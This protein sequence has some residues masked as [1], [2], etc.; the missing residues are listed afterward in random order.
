MYTDLDTAKQA[1]LAEVKQLE[2]EFLLFDESWTN[3]QRASLAQR[4]EN[5]MQFLQTIIEVQAQVQ[6]NDAVANLLLSHL[7]LM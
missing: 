7:G 4:Q 2:N 5:L 3:E 1:C 6:A